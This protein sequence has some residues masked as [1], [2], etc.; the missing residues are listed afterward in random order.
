MSFGLSFPWSTSW[1]SVQNFIFHSCYT[2]YFT[3]VTLLMISVTFSQLRLHFS[4]EN[5]NFIFYNCNFLT[6][7][8]LYL[9]ILF[10]TFFISQICCFIFQN[11]QLSHNCNLLHFTQMLLFCKIAMLFLI[12]VTIVFICKSLWIKASAKWL[13][14]YLIIA[15]LTIATLF[16]TVYLS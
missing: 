2:L 12:T 5:C 9:T 4:S 15:T 16:L 13:N 11:L 14:V 8:T 7:A 10:L 3:I 1:T 6:V